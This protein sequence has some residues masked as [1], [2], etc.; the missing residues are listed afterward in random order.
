MP[1]KITRVMKLKKN[2]KMYNINFKPNFIKVDNIP[3]IIAFRC[4][5]VYQFKYDKIVAKGFEN[6]FRQF[7]KKVNH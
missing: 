6:K 1:W 3:T 7:I 2:K 5:T 4:N